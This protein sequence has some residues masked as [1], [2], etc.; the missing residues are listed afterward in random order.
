MVGEE[1][2]MSGNI[3]FKS[4]YIFACKREWW[5]MTTTKGAWGWTTCLELCLGDFSIAV[6][7][8]LPILL[9]T[10]EVFSALRSSFAKVL[11]IIAFSHYACRSV[12]CEAS[13][14]NQTTIWIQFNWAICLQTSKYIHCYSFTLFRSKS[15]LVN[16]AVFGIAN[17]ITA[18]VNGLVKAFFYVSLYE[19]ILYKHYVPTRNVAI[20]GVAYTPWWDLGTFALQRLV[21]G[22]TPDA[23][24]QILMV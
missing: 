2:C 4:K 19:H 1:W 15:L 22:H 5:E 14:A 7:G 20:S 23:S 21:G 6:K 10:T 24:S 8:C 9:V 3:W 12:L 17:F 18:C 11:F 16:V 13:W